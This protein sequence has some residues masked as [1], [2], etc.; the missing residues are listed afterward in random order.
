MLRAKPFNYGKRPLPLCPDVQTTGVDPKIA[1]GYGTFYPKCPCLQ[2]PLLTHTSL[3]LTSRH[4][5]HHLSVF[6]HFDAQAGWGKGILHVLLRVL[7]VNF[8]IGYAFPSTY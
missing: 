5:K 8:L 7:A 2:L 6:R 1:L 4:H 3:L